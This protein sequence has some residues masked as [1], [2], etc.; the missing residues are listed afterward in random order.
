MSIKS[1]TYL[2]VAALVA[3][4]GYWWWRN[5]S[6]APVGASSAFG[7]SLG[8][9]QLPPVAASN[10][11]GVTAKAVVSTTAGVGAAAACASAGAAVAS[12]LC[13]MA[14][15]YLGGKAYDA[16]SSLVSTIKGWF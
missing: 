1:L 8:G 15:G 4:V 7:Q 13:G 14:G 2:A 11:P 12:P 9:Y 5:R 6:P 16:G 10:S 3:A